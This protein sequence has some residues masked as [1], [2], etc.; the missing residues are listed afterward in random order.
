ML[1]KYLK[2][3]FLHLQIIY[4][5]HKNVQGIFYKKVSSL[6]FRK[7]FKFSNINILYE[8]LNDYVS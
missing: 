6:F 7:D 4:P 5:P 3:F 2:C 1:F 8:E